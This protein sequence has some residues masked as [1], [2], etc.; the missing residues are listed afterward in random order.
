MREVIESQYHANGINLTVYEWPADG[1]KVFFAHATGF[2]ARCWDGVIERLPG[3]H[4]YAIDMRGHGRSDK[5]EPPYVWRNFGIDVAEVGEQLGLKGA[6][7]VGHSKGGYATIM[8]AAIKPELF[9]RLLLIDPTVLPKAAYMRKYEEEPTVHFSAK[10]R[11]EWASV[12]EMYERFKGRPPYDTWDPAVLRHY[13]EYGLLPSP[14][15]HGFVLA[16]PP[17]IEAATYGAIGGEEIHEQLAGVTCPVR[18]IRARQRVEGQP[19]DFRNSPTMPDLV[20][21]FVNGEDILMPEFTHFMPMEEPEW[22][23]G[24]VREM[25]ALL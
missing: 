9:G 8:A 21:H 19:Y 10:R 18:I 20:T 25:A 7:G 2:H 17:E 15:G 24:Q 13:C 16:C 11:N 4:C 23:A 6:L 22:V 3:L 1:P 12:D 14:S 5:P